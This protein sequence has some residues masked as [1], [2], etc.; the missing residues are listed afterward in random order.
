MKKAFLLL[1]IFTVSLNYSA[2]YNPYG[3]ASDADDE[4]TCI[5]E[6]TC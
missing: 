6:G 1:M 2:V 5:L 4:E 3:I